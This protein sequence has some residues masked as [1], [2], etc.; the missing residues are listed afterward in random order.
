MHVGLFVISIWFMVV[1]F[2]QSVY[3]SHNMEFLVVLLRIL[4]PQPNLR[5]F[6]ESVRVR[7]RGFFAAVSDGFGSSVRESIYLSG[8][9]VFKRRCVTC[10]PPSSYP[11][12]SSFAKVWVDG[13]T[14]ITAVVGSGRRM[15]H[16]A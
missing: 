6:H 16:V 11:R 4:N 8:V 5:I 13:S 1:S 7:I 15:V 3:Y 2:L 9:A 14:M 10:R 12:P